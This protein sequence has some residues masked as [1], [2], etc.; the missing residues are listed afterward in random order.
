MKT[1]WAAATASAGLLAAGMPVLAHHSFSAQYDASKP[2]DVKGVVTQVDWTNP[3]A[4]FYIEVK[5][6]Q[7][8]VKA[9]NF[10]LA[11]PNV[12]VRN[13]WKRNTL[14]IGEPI[15]VSGFLARMSPASGPQMAIAGSVTAADGRQLFASSAQDLR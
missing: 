3:H 13:G 11:S 8:Q 12:L 6:D 10:E 14:K 1:L 4:R 7:G 2:V 9:W 15:A 5:D